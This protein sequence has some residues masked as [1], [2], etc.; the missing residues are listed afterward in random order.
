VTL[1]V[2]TPEWALVHA[3]ADDGV[4]ELTN[5]LVD[6]WDAQQAR[7]DVAS[8]AA[9]IEANGS[10]NID[11]RIETIAL[12]G[13]MVSVCGPIAR[14][15][16]LALLP[17]YERSPII[18]PDQFT[19]TEQ[20]FNPYHDRI[21]R[22]AS[23][24]GISGGAV[25]TGVPNKEWRDP[26]PPI[27]KQGER[28]AGGF[29][30]DSAYGTNTGL[31]RAGE[32]AFVKLSGGRILHAAGKGEMSPLDVR[33]DGFGF[34]V[35]A[36][37]T[38]SQGYKATPKP[39]ERAQKEAEAK[40]LGVKPALSI[41]VMDSDGRRAHIYWRPGLMGGRLSRKKGWQYLGSTGIEGAPAQFTE[42]F[43]DWI[44]LQMELRF[45]EAEKF[46]QRYLPKLIVN[47]TNETRRAIREAILL[48]FQTGKHPYQMA[49]EIQR[50][51]GMTPGQV[52]AYQRFAANLVRGNMSANGQAVALANY[53][54]DA[55]HRRAR[56]IARTETLRA[57]NSGQHTLWRMAGA[58]GLLG[59]AKR[60]W[61]NTPGART[62]EACRDMGGEIAPVDGVWVADG[63]GVES[64]PLHPSCRCAMGLVF[65]DLK[66]S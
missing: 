21:G 51:V 20:F 64:P 6:A 27:G 23:A 14:D 4:T 8:L 63:F 48:G 37:S 34:E 65:D 16:A 60:I 41:V 59:S 57:A 28:K 18:T 54:H 13:A 10:D 26:P 33:V 46:L 7:I 44:D 22:F 35:K 43:A 58:N 15:T 5:A 36:V 32:K 12:Q 49:E 40:R 53:R 31:G 42:T 11:W 66:L 17:K 52:R 9:S 24:G 45:M 47:I 29:S 55:I 62:C 56:N 38:R 3:I 39:Y 19:E 2:R 50:M 1:A 61:I 25:I 30:A